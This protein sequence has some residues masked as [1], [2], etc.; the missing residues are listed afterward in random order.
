M[1]T[2]ICLYGHD[3]NYIDNYSPFIIWLGSQHI[4]YEIIFLKQTISEHDS[5]RLFY[6]RKML[7][8]KFITPLEEFRRK[9]IIRF[10]R[11]I[12]LLE[13]A[14][15][16]FFTIRHLA[17][18]FQKKS[19]SHLIASDDRT[20][21]ACVVIAAARQKIPTVILY[22]VEGLQTL[23]GA[24]LPKLQETKSLPPSLA[25]N[26]ATMLSKLI[27][28]VNTI[29]TQNYDASFIAPREVL[30]LYPLRIFPKNPWIR[31]TNAIDWVA[32]NSSMQAEENA[33]L[34]MKSG[35]MR[36]TGFPPHDNLHALI[37]A[38]ARG[39]EKFNKILDIDLSKKIFLIVGTSYSDDFHPR[40]FPALDLEVNQVLTHLSETLQDQFYF[41][42][43]PHPRME[44]KAQIQM[45]QKE[46]GKTIAFL[47]ADWIIYELIGVSDAIMNFVSA[48]TDA[49]LATDVPILSYK[50]KGRTI[51]ETETARYA[52]VIPVRTMD[53]LKENALS[54]KKSTVL[55]PQMKKFRERDRK[56][57]GMFDGKNTER[58]AD[59]LSIRPSPHENI[60]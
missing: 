18:F 48:S 32:V 43:K 56:K 52:S 40:Q 20:H 30:L 4:D 46:I 42:F 10:F 55:D 44:P 28:P 3:W 31:G 8:E 5:A 6:Y 54:L 22:P 1:D 36:V 58:F 9:P 29:H 11:K 50:L 51:F 19:Y 24:L 41:I 34:G 49:S 39:R 60:N 21:E 14:I 45:F 33:R 13:F 23:E 25:R 26:I 37:Q 35:K 7:G 15:E 17:S 12:P 59:L 2:K 16:T 57:F 27:Y 47:N 38:R 53:E